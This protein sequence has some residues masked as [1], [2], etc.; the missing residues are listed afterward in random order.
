MTIQTTAAQEL[1]DQVLATMKDTPDPRLREIATS[2]VRHLHEFAAEVNLT[3]AEWMYGVQFLTAV[4]QYSK[5]DRNEFILLSD[6]LGVSSLVETINQDSGE[7]ATE[8]TVLGPFYIPGAPQRA[9][10]Q[11]MVETPDAA[12]E[13]HISGTIR[14]TDGSPIAGATID[15]WQ[16]NSKGLYP[17]QDASQTPTNL[18]GIYTT[19]AN[20]HYEIVT[21]RPVSYPVPTDGPVGPMLKAMNRSEMRATHVH[22]LVAAP[23]H[24]TVVTHIFDSECQYLKTDAVFS[25]KESLVRKFQPVDGPFEADFDVTLTPARQARTIVAPTT[26]R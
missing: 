7:G 6:V 13:L 16:A 9:N 12:P 17:A 1:L 18:R 15:A 20:G 21:T 26:S 14:S 22:L 5:P 23:G 24:E 4:G 3:Q 19:D 10:G 11:S 2:L 25:V 8:A